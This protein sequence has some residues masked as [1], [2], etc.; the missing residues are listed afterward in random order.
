MPTQQQPTAAM[1]DLVPEELRCGLI[2]SPAQHSLKEI[3][4]K[5]APTCF[6]REGV[7]CS[8]CPAAAGCSKY[9]N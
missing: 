7:F 8:R 4:A 5:T 1:K 9:F 6:S 3:L 2:G